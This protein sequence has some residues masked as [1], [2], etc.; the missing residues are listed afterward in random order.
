MGRFGIVEIIVILV[1]VIG[2]FFLIREVICWYYKINK[3]IEL[4]E[5]TNSLLKKLIEVN[6]PKT[7]TEIYPRIISGE[8]SS[9]NDPGVMNKIISDLNKK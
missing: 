1:V 5:E 4:Q 7:V 9:V 2:V 3:Q 8:E 6:T